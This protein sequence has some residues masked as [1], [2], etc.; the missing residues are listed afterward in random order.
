MLQ[1]IRVPDF[2]KRGGLVPVIIQEECTGSV[3]ILAYT[4]KEEFLETLASGEV[5]L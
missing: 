2:E 5:V 4:R 3:L 1:A